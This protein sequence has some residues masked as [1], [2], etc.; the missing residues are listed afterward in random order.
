[1]HSHLIRIRNFRGCVVRSLSLVFNERYA[2]STNFQLN[3]TE[4]SD[5]G[6]NK[7]PDTALKQLTECELARRSELLLAENAGWLALNHDKLVSGSH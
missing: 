3:H 2:M 7:K 5:S 4:T 6:P 1:M